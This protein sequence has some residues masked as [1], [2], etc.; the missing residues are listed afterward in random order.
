MS[1]LLDTAARL[2]ADRDAFLNANDEAQ[3]AW[4]ESDRA[5]IQSQEE[6]AARRLM[7]TVALEQSYF[8]RMGW[9]F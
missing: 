8:S 3:R 9:G 1:T 6:R 5:Y 7:E 2:D 4:I